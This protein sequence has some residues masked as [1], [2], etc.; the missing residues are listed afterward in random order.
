MNAGLSLLTPEDAPY[1]HTL[2]ARCFASEDVWTVTA[3]RDSLS[4]PSVLALA[5]REDEKVHGM[6]LVQRVQP[7]AEILTLAVDPEHRRRGLAGQFIAGLYPLLGPYG[8]DRLL[9]EVAADNTPAKHFYEKYGFC[10]DGRRKNYY[11]RH[12]EKRVDAILMSRTLA[13]HAAE[14]EA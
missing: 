3:L 5:K 10:E 9:L 2:H 8:I 1:A 14:S 12:G 11:Q 4:A 13:G 7:D 6:I